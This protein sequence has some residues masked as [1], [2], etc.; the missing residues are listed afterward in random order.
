MINHW[1]VT[2]IIF[3]LMYTCVFLHLSIYIYAYVIKMMRV[4]PS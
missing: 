2:I 4:C 3:I 1:Y